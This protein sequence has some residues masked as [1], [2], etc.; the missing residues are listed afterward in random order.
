MNITNNSTNYDELNKTNFT[1]ADCEEHKDENENNLQEPVEET[2]EESIEAQEKD[3]V[4]EPVE[5]PVDD[6]VEDPV[7][8]PVEEQPKTIPYTQPVR[9]SKR[10]MFS[11]LLKDSTSTTSTIR[12]PNYNRATERFRVARATES[13]AIKGKTTFVTRAVD[14]QFGRYV[15]QGG[16]ILTNF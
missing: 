7:E 16:M 11:C 12:T 3:N 14:P 4:E 5:E 1:R 13:G 15:G 10:C 9:K 8:D 2:D 6:Q